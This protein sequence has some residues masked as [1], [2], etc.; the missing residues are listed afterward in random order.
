MASTPSLEQLGAL[1]ELARSLG[2]EELFV[3][4][5]TDGRDTLPRDGARFVQ[6]VEGWCAGGRGRSTPAARDSA[7][8][9]TRARVASV[10][11]RYYAMDRDCRWERIQ[12][13][14]DLLVHGRAEHHA[15]TALE[16]VEAAY[17]RG[18]TDEFISPT[19][20]G[21]PA[22]IGPGDSVLC[23]NFRPDRMRELTRALA[24]PGFGQGAEQLPGWSGRGGRL[25]SSIWRP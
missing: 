21:E 18:E 20:V 12:L 9:G 5:F 14:Y 15:G 2:T 19:T 4:C 24:E 11:G 8:A 10:I 6:T 25:R 16:A 3:H 13:A 23:F 17:G 7:S 22:A 1:I